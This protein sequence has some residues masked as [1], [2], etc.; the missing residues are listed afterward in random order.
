MAEEKKDVPVQDAQAAQPQPQAQ[1]QAQQQQAAQP[2]A[3]GQPNAQA[4]MAALVQQLNVAKAIAVKE[5]TRSEEL[6]NLVNRM[7]A[8]FDN[9]RKR[10]AELNKKQREAG[11]VSVI[12]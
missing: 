3:A 2:Q 7:Q 12:E 4:Q 9:Y 11:I 1:P 10:N 8:D 6:A 5:K